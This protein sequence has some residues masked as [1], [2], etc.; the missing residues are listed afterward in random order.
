[1]SDASRF[2]AENEAH[3]IKVA[4]MPFGLGP[5][6]CVGKSMATL[7]L[8]L[9]MAKLLLQYRLELGPSQ[10]PPTS[11]CT[12]RHV[13]KAPKPYVRLP[14][15]PKAS[16]T[17]GDHSSWRPS[18]E[19]EVMNASEQQDNHVFRGPEEDCDGPSTTPNADDECVTPKKARPDN[20]EDYSDAESSTPLK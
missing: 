13:S 3:L 15:R 17:G 18:D 12:R 19:D 9:A 4:Y 7:I 16:A 5:R 6:N 11:R 8:K 10:M 2:G 1:M 20:Q 14:R